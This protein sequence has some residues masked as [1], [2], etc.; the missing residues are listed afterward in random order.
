METTFWTYAAGVNRWVLYAT[1]LLAIGSAMFLISIR[2][3]SSGRG[4]AIS[5]GTFSCAVAGLTFMLAVGLGG[6]D[7]LAGPLSILLTPE[8]W[9]L[10]FDS[11]LGRSGLLGV[12]AAAGLL[13]GFKTQRPPLLM[14]GI[15]GLVG[16]FLLTGHAA[17]V[18]PVWLMQTMV[19]MHMA[20]AGF[21]FGSLMP[22][23]RVARTDPP[24]QASAVMVEFSRLAIWLVALLVASGA[25]MSYV[26][27]KRPAAL[28]SSDY[29]SRL[30]AKLAL[31]GLLLGLA[32]YNKLKLTPR[33]TAGDQEGAR[34][35]RRSILW[36]YALFVV[37]LGVA[38]LLGMSAPPRAG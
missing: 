13:V 31:F 15:A 34:L 19:A 26:Q 2:S 33:L 17:A 27:L 12:V 32:A 4:V 29:G 38:T 30:I 14:L 3:S 35:L 1:A 7:M 18:K 6:A 20:V 37:I 24:A 21:W 22:L 11:T 10:G 36:E 9:S 16:S 23:Y 28:F 5:T 8:V 25:V